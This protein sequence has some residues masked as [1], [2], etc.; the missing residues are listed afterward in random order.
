MA[1]NEPTKDE[2]LFGDVRTMAQAPEPEP[3][4]VIEVAEVEVVEEV[5]TPAER[6]ALLKSLE[7][8]EAIIEANLG[9]FRETGEALIRIR[10]G[11]AYRVLPEDYK[12]FEDYCQRR[13]DMT[14]NYGRRLIAA[15]TV[16]SAMVPNGTV[17]PPKREAQVREL[18]PLKDDPEALQAAW[19]GAVKLAGGD[20]PKAKQVREAVEQYRPG[21]FAI[22]TAGTEDV[23][24][25]APFSMPVLRVI[26]EL[27]EGYAGKVLDPFAG[28]GR[29]HLL[30]E[31]G[32]ETTGIEIEK[33]WANLSEFT[34]VGS[35]LKTRFRKGT[36]DAIA[37]SPTYGNR[38]ADS[39]DATD[40]DQR[41]SYHFE[42]GHKP[43]EGSSAV[44]PWGDEY[45]AFHVKAWKEAVRVLKP[46]GRFILNIK[47]HIRDGIWQDVAAWHV[48]TIMGL[49]FTMGAIRPIGTKGMPSGSNADVRSDAEL[50]I[51]FD[52]KGA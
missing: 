15:A 49:G 41:H 26:R 4:E 1:D 12:T 32:F 8:D 27:L 52:R 18:L 28:I 31:F 11:K 34:E 13:W 50:V 17:L 19:S 21:A 16:A 2:D 7:Q 3:V 48:T 9:A 45:E 43:S 33:E 39:Y 37:T 5:M 51:A 46:N 25:P 44:L 42:L 10:D 40:P 36:F 35:A 6:K 29:I 22:P 30:R 47:D 38:L 20:Q 24:H 23:K 14:P